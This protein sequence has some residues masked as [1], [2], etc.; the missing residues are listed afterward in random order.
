[1]T[2]DNPAVG[3]G[4][5]FRYTEEMALM[6]DAARNFAEKEIRPSVM[7]FDEAQKFPQSVVE[8]MASLGFLGALV[9]TSLGGAGLTPREFVVI[10]EEI[11]RVDPSVGLTLAAHSGLCLQHLLLFANDR[12]ARQYIPD[13]AAGRKIGSWCL[14]EASSGSDAGGMKTT[15]LADG[16]A[17]V[18]SGTKSFITNGSFAGTFV[19][20]ALTEP[21]KGKKGISAFVVERAWKGVSVGKKENKLG[22]RASDTVQVVFDHVRVPRENLLGSEGEGFKQAL[23]VLDGGRI[24]IAALSVG[25]AQGALDASIKYSRQRKQFG[26]ALA[27]FQAIQFS[28]ATMATEVEAARLLTYRA[29]HARSRGENVTSQAAKAKY[30]ASE[31]AQRAASAAVQIHGGYGF[32]KDFPVEKFYRDAKLLTIGE[33]TSEVQKMVI[34]KELLA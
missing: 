4:I 13:L 23:E 16:D 28:L 9:P 31:L 32:I 10:M 29:A 2:N 5:D 3:T 25:L 21:S 20:M 6:R 30:F 22:M 27:E 7:E 18:L 8:K 24:G 12:Q 34:A 19:V 14:T 17:Y 26:K 1:M 15:A 33:G 11:S